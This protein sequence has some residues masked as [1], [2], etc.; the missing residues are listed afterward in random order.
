MICLHPHRH[1]SLLVTRLR[2]NSADDRTYYKNCVDLL[3][4]CPKDELPANTQKIAKTSTL[5][6]T[7]ILCNE[8]RALK[9]SSY[10]AA[11]AAHT[12]SV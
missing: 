9:D 12:Q 6:S 11:I 8:V 2:D 1:A 7:Y 4:I 5:I 10:T 3:R